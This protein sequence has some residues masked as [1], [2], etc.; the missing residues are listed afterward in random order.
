MNL[1]RIGKL[2]EQ[3]V[4]KFELDLSNLTVFTE[5]AT[6]H[7]ALTA[8]IAASA[9]AEKVLAIA[10]DSRYGTASEAAEATLALARDR[11]V[12]N[13]IEVIRS[14]TDQRIAQADIIT[15]LG[16]V[17]PIDKA[18]LRHLKQ[19]AVIPLMWETWE[20]RP[21][22]LDLEAARGSGIAVLGTN[23]HH[24][25]LMIPGYVGHI[26]LKLLL[27]TEVEVYRSEIVVIGSG[28]FAVQT[29]ATLGSAGAK[30]TLVPATRESLRSEPARQA[31]RSADAIVLMEHQE[32]NQIIGAKGMITA[33]ELHELNPVLTIVHVTGGVDR[34]ALEELGITCHPARFAPPAYMSAAT[35]YLGPRPLIDLHAA[36]L[37]VGELLVRAR[38]RGLSAPQ[39]ELEVLARSTLAQGF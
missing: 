19:T 28:E 5:A 22:D 30:V 1:I 15:N 36:G 10:A 8:T 21:E 4:A 34:A 33:P 2:I 25:D 39:A 17:R 13:R 38:Q 12:V 11:K 32:R 37:K 24:P 35:D 31:F 18:L 6:G 20:F 29:Q 16:F 14:K 9:R 26:A 3:A 23:E 7:Y 27:E